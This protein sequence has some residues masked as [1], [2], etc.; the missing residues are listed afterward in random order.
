MDYDS[1]LLEENNKINIYANML[2]KDVFGSIK[3]KYIFTDYYCHGRKNF[4]V[5]KYIFFILLAEKNME[6]FMDSP[7]ILNGKL[8]DGKYNLFITEDNI[9]LLFM[10]LKIYIFKGINELKYDPIF[11]EIYNKKIFKYDNFLEKETILIEK[12]I[13]CQIKNELIIEEIKR[14]KLSSI[15]SYLIISY[16]LYKYDKNKKNDFFKFI[17]NVESIIDEFLK[18]PNN[19]NIDNY[20]FWNY[21]ISC[22]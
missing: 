15:G 6:L 3:N 4:I 18:N 13:D 20:T 9:I 12:N 21:L 11:Q 1:L 5:D 10:R 2:I 7:S 19:L 17:D 22:I 16:Y 8:N 14:V